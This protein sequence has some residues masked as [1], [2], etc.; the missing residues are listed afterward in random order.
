MTKLAPVGFWF[1]RHGETDWNAA[2]LAQGRV[3]TRLNARGLQQAE[4]A[5][6]ALRD[7]GIGRL[8]SSPL[9]RARQTADVVGDAIGLVP[10]FDPDL[11]ETSYGVEE[12][13]PMD[14][15]FAD[16]TAGLSTPDGA[17]S[18]DELSARAVLAVNRC[19]G[20]GGPALI[21]SHGAL[22]RSLRSAMGLDRNVR[23]PNAVPIWCAPVESGW[24]LTALRIG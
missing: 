21:V 7:R 15:W 13:K 2:N 17:E 10:A 14:D 16:W 6:A 19:I 9:L 12:G 11:R 1:L 20:D 4:A 3:E 5:A 23:T 18:F 22:F 24:Q 8:W